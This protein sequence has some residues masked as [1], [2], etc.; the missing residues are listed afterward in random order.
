MKPPPPTSTRYLEEAQFHDRWAQ[1]VKIEDIKPLDQF[2]SPTAVEYQALFQHI[3]PVTGK[4]VL[5]L[6]CGLG[7]EAIYFALKGAQVTA[8]DISP[9]MIATTKKLAAKWKVSKRVN[10]LVLSSDALTSKITQSFDCVVGCNLLHHVDI[11][12]TCL[13]V[14]KLIKQKGKVV[15][16]EPLAYNPIINIYRNMSSN[17]RTSGERPLNQSDINHITKIFPDF[18]LQEYHLTTLL[19]FIWFYVGEGLHPN[20]VRYWKKLVNEGQRYGPAF[21]LLHG[22]DT[23]LLKYIPVSKY[24]CWEILIDVTAR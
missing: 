16:I 17:V 15:F 20:Q 9:Q 7:E 8:I 10:C 5:V 1:S 2:E 22:I 3:S 19:L 21:R 4:K 23:W 18:R 13:E 14:K 11:K 24:L 6:G 12:K